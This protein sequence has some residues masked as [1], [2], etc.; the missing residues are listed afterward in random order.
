M[1]R[2][3]RV[4]GLLA[5]VCLVLTIVLVHA[6]DRE[7]RQTNLVSDL[8]GQARRTDAHLVNPWGIAQ[9]PVSGLLWLAD[10][11]AGVATPYFLTGRP[12][13]APRAP[14]VVT[15]PPPPASPAPAAPPVTPFNPT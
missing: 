9:S 13:P 14:P 15:L 7:V 10:N 12:P 11:G 3:T 1:R 8:P 4:A 2:V 5:G 6:G